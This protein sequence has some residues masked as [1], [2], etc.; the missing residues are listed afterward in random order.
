[1]Q[2]L[3]P[4]QSEWLVL[5]TEVQVGSVVQL[6]TEARMDVCGLCCFWLWAI[7]SPGAIFVSLTCILKALLLAV[8]CAAAEVHD[9]RKSLPLHVSIFCTGRYF[10]YM[11][12]K[13]VST[14]SATTL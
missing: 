9:D 3:G 4:C 2:P 7:L 6:P 12:K 10:A 14:K 1:M 8:S 11:Q 5:P 13:N